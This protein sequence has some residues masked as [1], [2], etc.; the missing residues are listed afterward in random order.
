MSIKLITISIFAYLTFSY[1]TVKEQQIEPVITKTLRSIYTNNVDSFQTYSTSIKSLEK[2]FLAY[3][4]FWNYRIQGKTNKKELTNEIEQ[5]IEEL[6][7][8]DKNKLSDYYKKLFLGLLYGIK[9]YINVEDSFL[10]PINSARKS[11]N[12]FEELNTEHPTSDA[13][14]GKAASMLMQPLYFEDSFF[15]TSIL[16]YNHKIQNGIKLLDKI[17]QTG[18]VTGTEA[19]L[20]LIEYYEKIMGNIQKANKY[21]LR[22][23]QKNTKSTYFQF[24]HANH[25]FKLGKYQKALTIF[26]KINNNLED[27]FYPFHFSSIILEA[28]CYT[29]LKKFDKAQLIIAYA[30]KIY[31]S[32][33]L[34][35]AEAEILLLKNNIPASVELLGEKKYLRE[36]GQLDTIKILNY[37]R[38]LQY[39]TDL[40]C[41]NLIDSIHIGRFVKTKIDITNK[42]HFQLQKDLLQILFE[43]GRYSKLNNLILN[44]SKT[45]NILNDKYNM[46]N[47]SLLNFRSKLNQGKYEEADKIME[48]TRDK[49]GNDIEKFYD[50]KRLKLLQNITQNYLRK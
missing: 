22:T 43:R 7:D 38:Y 36:N 48:K 50:I 44:I 19:T 23:L 40:H 29:Y 12:I 34:K 3:S 4:H 30:R 15:I 16:G 26:T 1:C 28:K 47:L 31:D 17:S 24:I 10:Q 8:I 49:F 14:F 42:Q 18:T 13:L 37:K 5:C 33:D 25:L 2:A 39:R 21:S 20:L 41:N 9:A 11:L 35:K 46:L 27:K 32:T 6:E 45:K